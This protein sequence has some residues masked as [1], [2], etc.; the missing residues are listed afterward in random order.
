MREK[1]AGAGTAKLKIPR[2]HSRLHAGDRGG[3]LRARVR[4]RVRVRVRES[5][6]EREKERVG[7]VKR[8]RR[9]VGGGSGPAPMYNYIPVP[10]A[11]DNPVKFGPYL[12]PL[13]SPGREKKS[14]LINRSVDSSGQGP[15]PPP[16]SSGQTL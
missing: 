9:L 3:V 16:L 10:G 15:R 5:E 8:I 4:V 11:L 12:P 13:S 14:A 6:R 7:L 1:F 2:D